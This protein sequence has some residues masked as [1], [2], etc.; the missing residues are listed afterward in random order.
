INLGDKEK[1]TK[2]I[3]IKAA[4]AQ[5]DVQFFPESGFLVNGVKSK[6]AFKA[7]GTDGLGK[8]IKG[9]IKDGQGNTVTTFTTAHLG[10]GVFT[11][12]PQVGKSYNAHITYADGLEKVLP[13]PKAND[14]SYVLTIDN[15]NPAVVVVQVLAA[16]AATREPLNLVAQSGGKLLYAAK[17]NA[18]GAAINTAIPKS[19]FPSGM[20]QF[21]LFSALGQPLNERVIFIQRDDL[22]KPVISTVKQIYAP[23]EKIKLDITAKNGRDS[24]VEG[25]FS[26]SVIDETKV[27]VNEDDENTILS[28]ILLT[29]DIKGYV[30][31]PAYYFINPN[32]KTRANLDILML[33]QGYRRF[34]W[35]QLMSGNFLPPV[36]QPEKT[37]DI[38]GVVTQKGKPLAGAKITMLNT[39]G[40]VFTIDTTADAQ[41]KFRF[42]DLI[43]ADS[44]RVV[45]QARPASGKKNNVEIALDNIKPQLVTQNKNA[46]DMRINL[47]D[48]L[49][50]YLQYSKSFN[51]EQAK[52][53]LGN[54]TIMLKEVVVKEKRV[55]AKNSTNLNGAGNADQVLTSKDLTMG[56]ITLDM[57]LQGRLTGVIF[58]NGRA[59]STRNIGR[60][61]PMQIIVDGAY[62][63]V[64]FLRSINVNDV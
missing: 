11:L 58:Q 49:L 16:D 31:K 12:A 41:G 24:L 47:N 61:N 5:V 29:S 27:K 55:V 62:L 26:V 2:T 8:D 34:E 48:G 57:C 17:T 39:T 30:E 10:M 56:C 3:I 36:Y 18:A 64:D 23:R 51:D 14:N 7:T 6:V 22:L 50:T 38:S 25:S 33:T 15:S 4:S 9:I 63:D 53:G 42:D 60:G 20:V 46:A 59:Y 43:F 35:K 45:I 13:L 21:T 37:I 19:R 28:D 54:R 52:F 32:D 1:V 44:A 40:N